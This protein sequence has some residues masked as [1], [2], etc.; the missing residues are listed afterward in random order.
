MS[1]ENKA[2][3][4][5]GVTVSWINKTA[6]L[7]FFSRGHTIGTFAL[8]EAVWKFLISSRHPEDL[9]VSALKRVTDE[10][11]EKMDAIKRATEAKAQG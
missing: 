2:L 1:D 11:E 5:D 7:Q 9:R 4:A 10:I 8:E 3:F 6:V